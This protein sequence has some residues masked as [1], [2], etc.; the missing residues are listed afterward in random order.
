MSAYIK[1]YIY[2][3]IQKTLKHL[4]LQNI[5]EGRVFLY[6]VNIGC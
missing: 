2:I 5:S 6:G 3:H 1:H 4:F